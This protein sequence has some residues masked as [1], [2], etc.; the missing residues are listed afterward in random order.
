MVIGYMEFRKLE[1]ARKMFQVVSMHHLVIW[2]AMIS[3]YVES[4]QVEEEFKPFRKMTRS[5]VEPILSILSSVLRCIKMYVQQM[6]T[7]SDVE[8]TSGQVSDADHIDTLISCLCMVRPFVVRGASYSK[9]LNYLNTHII[10]IFDKL[11]EDRKLDLLTAL[12]EISSYRTPQ[13]SE[14]PGEDILERYKDFTHRQTGVELLPRATTK[15]LIHGVEWLN[16]V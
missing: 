16:T 9:F 4:F 15:N 13:D 2:T 8:T 10:H 14:R 7:T 3:S 5:G 11:P 12:A 6:G 1:F